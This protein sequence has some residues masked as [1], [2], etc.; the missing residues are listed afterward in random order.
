MSPNNIDWA[1]VSERVQY[2]LEKLALSVPEAARRAD[3]GHRTAYKIT[4]NEGVTTK[5]LYRFCKANGIP[6]DWVTSGAETN[7]P[8]WTRLREKVQGYPSVSGVMEKSPSYMHRPKTD[9]TLGSA[10]DALSV[11]TGIEPMEIMQVLM[12]HKQKKEV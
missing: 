1:G 5:T 6:M 2:A 3:M 9:I 12:A 4:R 8:D 11:H 10:L 7:E